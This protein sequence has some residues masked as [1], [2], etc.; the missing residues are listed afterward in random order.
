MATLP[1]SGTNIRLLSGVPFYSDYK[2][3]R[4]FSTVGEQ[5]NYFMER[6]PVHVMSNASFQRIEGSN[7]V[8]ANKH[9]DLLW[10]ANY[11]M[12]RNETYNKWFYGFI[13]KLE[14]G[15]E[16]MTKVYFEIDIYQTW[17]L[18]TTFKP[19]Y[20]IREHQK[21]WEANGSPVVNTID[22]G[23]DYGTE[24]DTVSVENIAPYDN[25]FFLVIVT[26]TK[27]HTSANDIEAVVNGVPQPLH[28]YVHPIKL[29]G[30]SD[31]LFNGTASLST[32]KTLLTNIFKQLTAVNNVVSLYITDYIGSNVGVSGQ[33]VN[34]NSEQFEYVTISDDVS[35]NVHTVHVKNLPT[36]TRKNIDV[37]NKYDGYENVKESKLLMYPYTSLVLDDFK[38]NRIELKTEYIA[39]TNIVLS[40]MGSIGTSN[41]TTYGLNNYNVTP[42][43]SLQERND[44]LIENSIINS[45]PNDISILNDNLAAFIQG[46]RN[47]L[48]NQKSS[49][50]FNTG[51]QMA[52]S[53]ISGASSASSPTPN[54]G[55][56]ASS[57]VGA[58]QGAGNMAL[59]LQG[60]QAKQQDISNTPPQMAKMGGNMA[61]DFGNGYTGMYVIKKQI[62]KEYRDQ[63]TN[64]FNMFGY[65]QNKTKIPNFKT[66][67]YWNFVHTKGC[68]IT[69]FISNDDMVALKTIFDNGI[70]LWH[71]DDIGNYA[72]DNE[73]IA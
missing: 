25:V 16:G 8:K 29:N 19:S 54:I 40:V 62:K 44:L 12:F 26:K 27:I 49:I 14:Y 24:Y 66:R 23:L 57:V 1:L 35:V 42:G 3:T 70:T 61:F 63:L 6:T 52:Q 31:F 65:K 69:G 72:L 73:V 59:A 11:I 17:F 37:G 56:V 32:P 50:V 34:F 45:D 22:E 39:N 36:Y 43:V 18:S 58:V 13:T 64:F 28:Y 4:Y 33:N 68:T 2:D 21:L 48:A 10:S 7:M 67:R 5:T 46:N 9:I 55:G 71:T 41:K 51:V 47:S 15:S 38:G 30:E 20:V 53:A 60:I